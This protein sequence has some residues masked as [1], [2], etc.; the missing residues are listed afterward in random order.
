MVQVEKLTI[1]VLKHGKGQA[2]KQ[3]HFL[4]SC[5]FKD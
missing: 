4:L 3:Q 5:F 2:S 1:A